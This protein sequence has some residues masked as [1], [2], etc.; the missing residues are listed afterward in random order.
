MSA[1]EIFGVLMY[2]MSCAI[3]IVLG[4][5]MR[6]AQRRSRDRLRAQAALYEFTDRRQR[7]HSIEEIYECALDAIVGALRCGRASIL[8]FDDAGVMRFV[9]WR[10][11]SEEYR[12]AV[13]GHS[14]WRPGE[15][16]PRPVCI[17]NVA[18]A[19]LP[20]PLQGAI[21]REGIGACAFIPVVA[22]GTL[23][24]K[25]MVYYGAPHA[26]GSE[27]LALALT[28]A[29]QLAFGISRIRA[30]AERARAEEALRAKTAELERVEKLLREADRRKDDFLATLAHELRSPL[31]PIANMVEVMKRAEGD[32]ELLRKARD[33]I[34]RQTG[35]IVRLV[36]DLLDVSRIARDRLVLRKE[37]LELAPVVQQAVET[38]KA[39]AD[40]LEHELSVSL[41]AEPVHLYA[42][43]VRLA[44]VLTN[45]LHNA[46]KYTDRGGRIGLTAERRGG[47]V[48]VSVKDSGCGIAPEM[49][50]RIFDAFKNAEQRHALGG[51]GIGLT[52]ARRLVEMHGGTIAAF[53]EGEGRGAE[54]VVRLPALAYKPL[55]SA[56]SVA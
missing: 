27:D 3:I 5:A 41:P 44:Q 25:F 19:E 45:L 42:D 53:S 6:R 43:R 23:I 52:L 32:V 54:F 40:E 7:A 36:D 21:R 35:H 55:G 47:E 48:I 37:L 17:E 28:I 30:E 49:L 16:D 13:D 20:G 33:T 31:A 34:G 2:A 11:L 50:P 18:L 1:K 14:P 4:E 8:L 26:F 22:S 29:R 39:L 10:G 15:R 38:C 12:R 24:G 46:C 51:L 56:Q 9:A